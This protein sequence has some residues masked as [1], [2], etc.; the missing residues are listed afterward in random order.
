S[1]ALVFLGLKRDPAR[2]SREDR[3]L[4]AF[5]A[6]LRVS[7]P[8]RRGLLTIAFQCE[9]PELAAS[10]ANRLAE[11][12]ISMRTDSQKAP[13]AAARIVVFAVPPPYPVRGNSLLLT[14]AARAA[15]AFGVLVTFALPPLPLRRGFGAQLAQPKVFGDVHNFARVKL[16]ERLS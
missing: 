11:L 4:E 16:N 7:G 5:Q 15:L 12:Y 10:A 9:N 14:G 1:R 6:R 8:D 2:T 13:P 3:V